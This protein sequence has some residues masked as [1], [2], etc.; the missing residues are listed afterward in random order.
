MKIK[1]KKFGEFELKLDEVTQGAVEKFFKTLR[2][3]HPD[4]QNITGVE[5]Q[6]DTVRVA[7]KLGWVEPM[8]VVDD[9]SPAQ[10]RF[11]ATEIQRVLAESL[12]IPPN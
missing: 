2:E 7:L 4:N 3:D 9:V 5:Y 11:I 12:T 1:N 10:I 8:F 6:G